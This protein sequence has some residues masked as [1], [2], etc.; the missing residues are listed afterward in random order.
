MSGTPPVPRGEVPARLLAWWEGH[1]R[2]FPWR[3]P[4][5]SPFAVLLAEVLLKRTTA[6]AAARVY[7]VLLARYPN[8]HALAS[9]PP[10]E[11]EVILS[12]VGLQRQRAR[13]LK[14]MASYLC[15]NA[16]GEVPRDLGE[17][18]RVPHIG[19]YTAR[20]VLVFAFGEPL[21]LVDSNTVR[22]F[23]RL[24]GGTAPQGRGLRAY[25]GLA[26]SLVP[27]DRPREYNWAFM[28]FAALVCRPGAPQC[29]TCPLGHVCAT[30]T[31]APGGSPDQRGLCGGDRPPHGGR[32]QES[33]Y[34][35]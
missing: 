21:G 25:Q 14:E 23:Q 10:G 3:E 5:L 11:L 29:G 15:A 31:A 34:R 6:T 20:A 24:F 13:G 35:D 4:G 33:G 8:A 9:A 7:P 28:D 26:D 17:L 16:G 22:V 1:R 30:R 2:H 19:P 18:L 27:P 32:D 12:G